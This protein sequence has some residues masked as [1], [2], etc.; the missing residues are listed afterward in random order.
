MCLI[1]SFIYVYSEKLLQTELGIFIEFW[2]LKIILPANSNKLDFQDNQGYPKISF[3]NDFCR[4][5]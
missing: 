1:Y 3:C 2:M 5:R 4:E